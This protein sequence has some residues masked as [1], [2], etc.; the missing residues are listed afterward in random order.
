LQLINLLQHP[1]GAD[2]LVLG[3][4]E[5]IAGRAALPDLI[6]AARDPERQQRVLRINRLGPAVM[7]ERPASNA[8]CQRASSP[9]ERPGW[10][11]DL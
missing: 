8:A 3:A 10:C 1:Q 4:D 7:G 6:E 2:V 11:S 5:I 9:G